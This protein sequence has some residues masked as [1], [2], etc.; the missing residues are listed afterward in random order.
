[1]TRFWFQFSL[2]SYC[3]DCTVEFWRFLM[4]F[5]SF[6]IF[7]PFVSRLWSSTDIWAYMCFEE[8]SPSP[9]LSAI[10]FCIFGVLEFWIHLDLDISRILDPVLSTL[11][12]RHGV[13]D[14]WQSHALDASLQDLDV[15][16]NRKLGGKWCKVAICQQMPMSIFFTRQI[17]RLV[18]SW[19]V[20]TLSLW[21]FWIVPTVAL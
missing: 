12:C 4:L 18:E 16:L 7:W 14:S 20:L 8:T 13:Q 17:P 9:T 6:Y 19:I 1:V 21:R 10:S 15:G 11:L 3:T 5:T 2:G